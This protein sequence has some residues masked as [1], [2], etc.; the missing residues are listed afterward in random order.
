M[1]GS[2]DAPSKHERTEGVPVRPEWARHDLGKRTFSMQAMQEVSNWS[3]G[4]RL[5]RIAAAF[6]I[7]ELY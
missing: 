3:E 4:Y 5:I 2:D 7:T 1:N 6:S